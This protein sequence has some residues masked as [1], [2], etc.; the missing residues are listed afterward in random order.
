MLCFWNQNNPLQLLSPHWSQTLRRGKMDRS[1]QDC[2]WTWCSL[3]GIPDSI[4]H[5]LNSEFMNCQ[6]QVK[7]G[8]NMYLAGL[9]MLNFFR[10]RGQYLKM[11]K[12]SNFW[13]LLNSWKIWQHWIIVTGGVAK[14]P[15]LIFW[16][17]YATF[18]HSPHRSLLSYTGLF[19]LFCDL[20][21]PWRHLSL[22]SLDSLLLRQQ[23]SA[24]VTFSMNFPDSEA[25][26]MPGTASQ[27][28]LRV[29]KE[30]WGY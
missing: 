1:Q 17:I 24:H 15:C 3:S 12:Y 16:G 9:H 23:N 14:W 2:L 25:P 29:C 18:S 13:L 6:P 21:R 28:D 19:H 30:W 10:I 5:F 20:L 22:R 8:P 26:L 11:I 27:Q 7:S 4:F